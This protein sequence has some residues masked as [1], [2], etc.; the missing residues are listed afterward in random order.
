[1]QCKNCSNSLRTDYSYCPNC[2]GKIIRNRLTVKNLWDDILERYF[3]LDNTFITTFKNLFSQPEIVIEGYIHGARK[4]YLNPISYLGIAITLSG[5]LVFFMKKNSGDLNM[6]ILGTGTSQVG[7]AKLWD[8]VLDYQ[9]IFFVMYIPMMAAAGWLNFQAQ[10]YN[11]SERVV[12]FMYTLAQYSLSIFIPSLIILAFFPKF[13]IWYSFLGIL[14]MYL[15][16][17]YVI[18]KIAREK[19][20]E[21]WSKIFIFWAVFTF[22]YLGI[23]IILPLIL[24]LTGSIQL[25]DFRPPSP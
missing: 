25:D 15:Y 2:G 18:K 22:F 7:Q 23:S 5:I 16:S 12:I 4:K 11:F 8:V 3:N 24:F 21:L 17:A 10:K 20:L 1:M 6:D 19:R 14:F 9:A 13:Y